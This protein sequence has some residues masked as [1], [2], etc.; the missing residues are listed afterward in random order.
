M[1][2][3]I[4]RGVI[5]FHI[6][7]PRLSTS[8]QAKPSQ[9]TPFLGFNSSHR[10]ALQNNP[11]LGFSSLHPISELGFSPT[12]L[13]S[14]HSTPRL[15]GKSAPGKSIQ[16]RARLQRNP[17]HVAPSQPNPRLQNIST[18][19]SS[20][21]GFSPS[22]LNSFHINPPLGYTTSVIVNVYRPQ[23]WERSWPRP[24]MLPYSKMAKRISLVM[25]PSSSTFSRNFRVGFSK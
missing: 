10:T 7:S 5:S 19:V 25:M 20:N 8:K 2:T 24:W 1:N 11:L 12:P 9:A 22:H 15:H 23:P 17:P 6:R 16:H 14:I 21:L 4:F 13:S 18:Q 3:V